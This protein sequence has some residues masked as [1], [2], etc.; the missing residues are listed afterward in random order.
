MISE[1]ETYA[2]SRRGSGFLI[3]ILVAQFSAF[4]GALGGCL[5]TSFLMEFNNF[6]LGIMT[7]KLGAD[8]LPTFLSAGCYF[9]LGAVHGIHML[10]RKGLH[11]GV[12]WWK[13]LMYATANIGGPYFNFPALKF[14]RIK[15]MRC[16]S[17][18][19]C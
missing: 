8:G 10:I 18:Q 5:F 11:L 19:I 13:Y 7:E 14:R 15:N 12:P 1:I 17:V 4:S 2:A 3:G 9:L 6:C 16:C